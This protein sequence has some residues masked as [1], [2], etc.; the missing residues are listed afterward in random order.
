MSRKFLGYRK[1]V[2]PDYGIR[3]SCSKEEMFSGVW[4]DEWK[5]TRGRAFQ[6]KG[7]HT[8]AGRQERIGCLRALHMAL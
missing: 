5:V 8:K 3:E 2:T 6:E 4:K 7:T 1:E